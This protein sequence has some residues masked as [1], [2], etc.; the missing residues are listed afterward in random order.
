MQGDSIKIAVQTERL[1]RKEWG[2][3]GPH[4]I[5]HFL[6]ERMTEYQ[7]RNGFAQ[8]TSNQYAIAFQCCLDY[9]VEVFIEQKWLRAQEVPVIQALIP[10]V[11][12]S[13]KN[14]YDQSDLPLYICEDIV[15][16]LPVE[17]VALSIAANPTSNHEIQWESQLTPHQWISDSRVYAQ[18]AKVLGSSC[19]DFVHNPS[20]NAIDHNYWQLKTNSATTMTLQKNFYL[21]REAQTWIPNRLRRW[22]DSYYSMITTFIKED[23]RANGT[24]T[25]PY[26]G[27]FTLKG[28]RLSFAASRHLKDRLKGKS[29]SA[30][31]VE[32]G[33]PF[34]GEQKPESSL[35]LWHHTAHQKLS[36]RRQ[37][38]LRM[39]NNKP[40]YW[41]N[42]A[43]ANL[44]FQNFCDAL[45]FR[46]ISG[47][48]V[49]WTGLG[50]LRPNEGR[51]HFRKS[52]AF[53]VNKD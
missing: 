27:T 13:T 30:K 40:Q 50:T 28:S 43:L 11:Q 19:P 49:L 20:A 10:D 34:G 51:V 47:K 6:R 18:V 15:A 17:I 31:R 4:L 52:R 39:A 33:R 16:V 8:G 32:C 44:A 7:F 2:P 3:I 21:Q 23:L 14:K 35:L 36:K 22:I 41:Q 42:K 12:I 9:Q 24:S 1:A 26:L 45:I 53:D 25:V 29:P 48:K 38:V 37:F 46:L 5:C